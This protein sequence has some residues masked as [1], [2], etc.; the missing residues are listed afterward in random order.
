M[1]RKLLILI[2]L[3][4]L[5][6]GCKQ[7]KKQS[8][9]TE[10]YNHELRERLFELGSKNQY[11][12]S[13]LNRHLIL[14]DRII[15]YWDLYFPEYTGIAEGSGFY[16]PQNDKADW[17][18]ELL[19]R[20]EEERI[21]EELRKM[22][23]ELKELSETAEPEEPFEEPAETEDETE[24]ETEEDTEVQSEATEENPAEPEPVKIETPKADEIEQFL[25]KQADGN[26]FTDSSS[27]LKFYEFENEIFVRQNTPDGMIIINSTGT[28]VIRYYYDNEMLLT[29]KETWKIFNGNSG[30]LSKLEEFEYS[31]PANKVIAKK[32]TSGDQQDFIRYTES[33][34]VVSVEKYVTYKK[35]QYALQKRNCE[36]NDDNKIISDEVIE[37]NYDAG[38]YKKLLYTFSKKYTYSYN[39]DDIPPDF[40]YYEDQVLKMKNKY[41]TEKGEYTSQVFF[42]EGL[43]VKTYYKN[44]VRVKDVY[45]LNNTVLREKVYETE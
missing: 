33:G 26:I 43:S 25:G 12:D 20:I 2:L 44:D 18:E 13:L 11:T 31:K 3:I 19:V 17:V 24:A 4:S 29:K 28:D 42:E 5:L 6:A 36:Y 32:Q 21:A 30:E 1:E 34:L 35:R 38:N 41:S 40:N 23:E 15:L 9:V 22:E 14:E 37:Y 7:T 10:A 39:E 8:E 45:Y 27:Q 16:I